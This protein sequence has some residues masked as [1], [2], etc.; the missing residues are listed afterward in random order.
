MSITL[1]NLKGYSGSAKSYFGNVESYF[2]NVKYYFG[3][4]KCYLGNV[5]CYLGNR[6]RDWATGSHTPE[7]RYGISVSRCKALF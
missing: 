3:N 1:G 5:K 4:V 6:S 2:R 7:K